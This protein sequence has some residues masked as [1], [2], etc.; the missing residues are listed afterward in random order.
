[1]NP[2]AIASDFRTIA[3]EVRRQ[4]VSD[5]A[6]AGLFIGALLLAWIGHLDLVS[7]LTR[8]AAAPKW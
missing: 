7:A 3:G 8:Y 1:M 2:S 5:I 6:R 4:Q